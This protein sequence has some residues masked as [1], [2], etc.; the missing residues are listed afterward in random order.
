MG[1][2]KKWPLRWSSEASQMLRQVFPTHGLLWNSP[3]RS[4]K[5][6]TNLNCLLSSNYGKKVRHIN[7]YFQRV[8]VP[9]VRITKNTSFHNFLGGM[10]PVHPH[11]RPLPS[12]KGKGISLFRFH[13]NLRALP[14]TMIYATCVNY[15]PYISAI[16]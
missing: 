10:P 12:Q 7:S 8:I 11:P 16:K 2:V 9:P 3:C 5:S 1:L 14:R 6:P 4:K 15:S 13:L